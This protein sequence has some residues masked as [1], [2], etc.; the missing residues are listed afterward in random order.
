MTCDLGN[1]GKHQPLPK[2]SFTSLDLVT[3]VSS[4]SRPYCSDLPQLTQAT[5][6]KVFLHTE[7]LLV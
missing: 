5:L 6:A 2:P 1:L 7:C 3:Y 4:S